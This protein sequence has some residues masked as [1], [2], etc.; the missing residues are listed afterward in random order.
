MDEWRDI[1]SAPKDGTPI[2]M[3][4]SGERRRVVFGWWSGRHDPE[5]PW[6]TYGEAYRVDIPTHWMPLPT[7]P[8]PAS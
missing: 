2:L 1:A 6:H 3:W 5:Y 7:P 8:S 4:V